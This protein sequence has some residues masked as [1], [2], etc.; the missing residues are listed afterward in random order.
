MHW[1]AS[2]SYCQADLSLTCR[3]C[4]SL[5]AGTSDMVHD[6]G[7]CGTQW[8]NCGELLCRSHGLSDLKS[9]EHAARG[10]HQHQPFPHHLVS[11][12]CTSMMHCAELADAQVAGKNAA[13]ISTLCWN[14]PRGSAI[15]A[16][17]INIHTPGKGAVRVA[18]ADLR[19]GRSFW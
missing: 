1:V 19:W 12:S 17:S 2:S 8:A 16:S 7:C 11:F 18:V 4:V 14:C 9:Q 10:R 6:G 15:W 13:Q 3:S 5:D